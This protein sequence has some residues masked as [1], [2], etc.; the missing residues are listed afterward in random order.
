MLSFP[1]IQSLHFWCIARTAYLLHLFLVLHP[2]Q[3]K[4][5]DFHLYSFCLDFSYMLCFF[6]RQLASWF[7]QISWSTDFFKRWKNLRLGVQGVSWYLLRKSKGIEI[8]LSL[9]KAWI[10]RLFSS[11]RIKQSPSGY[12]HLKVFFFFPKKKK[13][14]FCFVFFFSFCDNNLNPRQ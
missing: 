5:F 10:S 8:L 1:S 9:N 2:L 13:C 14:L 7:R 3:L 12:Q 11:F 4:V 6:L